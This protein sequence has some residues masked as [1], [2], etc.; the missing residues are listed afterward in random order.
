MKSILPYAALAIS[1]IMAGAAA[2]Q[3]AFVPGRELDAREQRIAYVVRKDVARGILTPDQ[4]RR[5]E[6]VLRR[7]RDEQ[8]NMRAQNGG[9]LTPDQFHGLNMRLDQL[10]H[11]ARGAAMSDLPQ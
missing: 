4:G 6:A 10:N 5:C 3:P 8:A 7:I 2:A 1:V 11:W 9:G